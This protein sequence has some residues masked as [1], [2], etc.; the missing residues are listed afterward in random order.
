MESSSTLKNRRIGEILI[1]CGLITDLQLEEALALKEHEDVRLGEALKRLG[2]LTDD[3]LTWALGIQFDL[4]YVDLQPEMINWEHLLQF[5]LDVLYELRMVPI[6]H[7][8]STT[9]AV[10]SDPGIPELAKRITELFPYDSVIVQLASEEAIIQTLNEAERLLMVAGV[11]NEPVVVTSHEP[12]TP[13]DLISLLDEKKASR[14]V[15]FQPGGMEGLVYMSD[16]P[17]QMSRSPLT[18]YG[19]ETVLSYIKEHF[20]CEFTLPEGVCALRPANHDL[21]LPALRFVSTLGADGWVATLERL[22]EGVSEP[23]NR[24]YYL[25]HSPSPVYCKSKLMELCQQPIGGV[26]GSLPY[27]SLE[28]RLDCLSKGWF[29]IELSDVGKR[30]AVARH[31]DSCLKP[32]LI[33]IEIES[34]F[35]IARLGS[36][37]TFPNCGAVFVLLRTPILPGEEITSPR[38]LKPVRLP[39]V[40]GDIERFITSL[41]KEE[42]PG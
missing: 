37:A 20:I 10:V 19:R 27:I 11:Y 33:L 1:S 8:G 28:V 40:Q 22:A 32:R 35:D 29:Q 2:H 38:F 36:F 24:Q 14:I 3:Q 31:L 6:S 39:P 21:E 17:G 25:L 34:V 9:T 41:L 16:E 18:Q 5:S 7:V 42:G 15:L 12:Q 4:S 13:S 23:V 26:P 30:I